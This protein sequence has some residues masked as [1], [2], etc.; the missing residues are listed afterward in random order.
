M[1]IIQRRKQNW[2]D[3]ADTT[4]KVNRLLVVDCSENIPQRPLLWW[5]NADARV[6]WAYERYQRQIEN[7]SWLHDNTVPSLNMLTGT[8]IFAEACGCNVHKSLDNPPCAIPFVFDIKDLSKIKI[9]KLENTKLITLFDM[10]DKLKARAGNDALLG[11]PDVQTPIDIA[12]LIWEKTDFF[13]TMYDDPEAIKDLCQK[14]KIFMFEFFDEWFKRYGKEIS[15][16]YPDYYMPYG[17]TISEDEIGTVSS[18]MFVEFFEEELHEISN[19]YGAI[20]IHCCADSKHQWENLK[21]VPNLKILNLCRDAEQT[22]SSLEIFRNVCGQYPQNI[23][24]DYASLENPEQ[25]HIAHYLH[26]ATK[27]EAIEIVNRFNYKF[28]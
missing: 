15:A 10:A 22:T 26:A 21:K 12:A 20:G 25:I 3:F 5:E 9:P 6:E 14:I 1:N 17:I 7:L 4:S 23:D 18:D 16:H 8:E 13:A 27:K 24:I 2:I 11:L 19:R 28:N